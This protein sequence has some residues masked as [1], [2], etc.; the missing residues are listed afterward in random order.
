VTVLALGGYYLGMQ[1]EVIAEHFK[2]IVE[3]LLVVVIIGLI[4][5]WFKKR[6]KKR[7]EI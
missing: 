6:S 1:I 4:I 5:F 3:L 7:F 2:I